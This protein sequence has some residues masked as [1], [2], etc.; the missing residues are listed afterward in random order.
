[1]V[2][3]KN[4]RIPPKLSIILYLLKD[5][6]NIHNI[7]FALTSQNIAQFRKIRVFQP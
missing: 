5:M 3:Y 1:M 4:W 7:S 6:S 2:F